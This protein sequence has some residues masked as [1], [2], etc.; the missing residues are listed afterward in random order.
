MQIRPVPPPPAARSRRRRPSLHAR[1]GT[2]RR[3]RSGRASGRLAAPDG[4]APCPRSPPPQV[5]PL[6]ARRRRGRSRHGA[7]R[8]PGGARPRGPRAHL[9]LAQ[10]PAPVPVRAPRARELPAQGPR[11][12]A[13]APAPAAQGRAARDPHDLARLARR[14]AA[15]TRCASPAARRARWPRAPTWCASPGATGARRPLR[16]APRAS[17]R[18]R[19]VL[20]PPPLPA[21]RRLRLRRRGQPLRRRPRATTAIRARTSPPRR[22]RRSW[23]R[24]AARSR[25]CGYQAASAGHYVVLD[26][27][28]EDRDYVFMHLLDGLDRR[29]R[30]ASGCA[31]GQ[32]IGQVGSTGRSTGPHLHFE[33]WTGGWFVKRREPDRPAAAPARLGRLVLGASLR[34]APP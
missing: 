27:R 10:A 8:R 16:R 6:R 18:G 33:V 14:R 9:L 17:S 15:P 25:R 11:P 19:L 24:A 34:R 28:D 26:G 2:G 32:R 13:R 22:A 1:K 30:R 4:L 5:A 31:P 20:L 7:S 29:D 3:R 12:R 23:P 21:R